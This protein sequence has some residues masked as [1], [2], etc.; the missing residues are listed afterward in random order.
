METQD[1]S[2]MMEGV[3]TAMLDALTKQRADWTARYD[4]L[5]ASG[6]DAS[7]FKAEFTQ[8]QRRLDE[9]EAILKRPAGTFG[10]LAPAAKSIGQLFVECEDMK[11]FAKH[12]SRGAAALNIEGSIFPRNLK[13]LIDSTAV[14]SSIPGILVPERVGGII[15]PPQR[16]LRVRDLIPFG[17]TQNNAVEFIRELLF[18]NAAS[19]QEE[20]HAKAE[21]SLTFEIAHADVQCIAHWIPATR[22]ILDDFAQLQAYIDTRLLDGLA[23]I[24][25]Q[26]L[27]NGTGIGQNLNGILTQATAVVGTFAQAGD[28]F[29]DQIARALTELGVDRYVADGIVMNEADWMTILTIKTEDGGANT[30]MYLMGG[31][32]SLGI[33]TLWGRPVVVTDAMAV[34]SFMVGQFTGSVMGFDRMRAQVA[35]STEHE[36]YFIK[37]KVAIRAEERLTVAVFRPAAFRS[38]AFV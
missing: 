26:Q 22:Q 4:E 1:V 2:I 31:P 38:G 8:H 12:W 24:E 16:R 9:V 15:K 29:I 30:G 19:P 5:K 23:D 36:D 13:T 7:A 25:D 21:A 34:G 11:R 17:T 3:K 37:N 14:G 6:V 20:G 35:V 32:G 18:T 27:L 33:P 10:E 28:T